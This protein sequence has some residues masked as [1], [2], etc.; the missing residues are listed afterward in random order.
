MRRFLQAFSH[1]KVWIPVLAALLIIA[2]LLTVWLLNRQEQNN[3]NTLRI[4]VESNRCGAFLEEMIRQFP[5]INFEIEIYAGANSAAYIDDLLSHGEAGDIIFYNQITKNEQNTSHLLDLS[6]YPF[7]GNLKDEVLGILDVNHRI[8]QIPA[9]MEVRCI[10]YNKTLFAE[11]GWEMPSNFQEHL[12]LVEAIRANGEGITPMAMGLADPSYPFSLVAT[13]SQCGYLST[14]NGARWQERFFRGEASVEEG[15]AEG[16]DMVAQLIDAGAF[17]AQNYIH[18]SACAEQ[19]INREAAMYCI[20]GDMT[21]FVQAIED[22][23]VTDEFGFVPFF[24]RDGGV[25]L[26]GFTASSAWSIN[27]NLAEDGNE[28]KLQHALKVME[29]ITTKQGQSLLSE[30]R[31]QLTVTKDMEHPLTETY[32]KELWQ[33]ANDGYKANALYRGYEHLMIECSRVIKEAMLA[34]S[35]A[36]MKEAFVQT[37]DDCN[38]N[39]LENN[40]KNAIAYL[41]TDLTMSQTAQLHAQALY[42]SGLGDLALTTHT[43]SKNHVVNPRGA[44][45]KLWAGEITPQRLYMINAKGHSRAMVL[46]LTGKQ[47][48][49]LIEEGKRVTYGLH[50]DL[51]GGAPFEAS[52]P[53]TAA[54]VYYWAGVDVIMENGKVVSMKKNG[55]ELSDTATYRVV[56]QENDYVKKMESYAIPTDRSMIRILTDYFGATPIINSIRVCRDDGEWEETK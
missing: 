38:R 56:M 13:L 22:P 49:T 28:T 6:G 32:L 48:K 10:A 35:S 45:G 14:P 40:R 17:D 36:G 47:I 19:I 2:V 31:G 55:Q 5:E 8:Y 30:G 44:A 53:L 11:K 9:P 54:F 33:L 25:P 20:W 29:W 46:H 52:G 1:K 7:M 41:T 39:Y 15:L 16:L 12:E 34:G 42:A 21:A 50:W 37:A 18:A 4:T 23:S 3:Q 51:D 27:R 43:G 24:S 26:V